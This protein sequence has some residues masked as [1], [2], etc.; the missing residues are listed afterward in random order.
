MS[1][2]IASEHRVGEHTVHGRRV[3]I[4]RLTWMNHPGA[5]FHVIDSETGDLL[6]ENEGFDQ[7]PTQEQLQAVV[8][9]A[10]ANSHATDGHDECF[11]VHAT[12][13]GHSDCDGNL[14]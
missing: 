1:D 14:L 13:D 12:A 7:P 5:S 2:N 4:H 9:Q 10:A 6:D 11:G 3:E 8:E